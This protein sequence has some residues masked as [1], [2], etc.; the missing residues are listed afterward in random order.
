MQCQRCRTLN[1]AGAQFCRACGARLESLC[2]RCN[3]RLEAD[4]RFCDSCGTDLATATTAATP[5]A[6]PAPPVQFGSPGAYTPKHLA[7]KILTS[8][9][10]LEGERK[11]V[12]VLFVD[13]SGFTSLS[14]R[15]DPEDVHRFM[16]RAFELMLEEVHRYEGTVNQF[17]GDGIMALFGAPIAHEDHAQRAV[18]AALGIAKTLESYHDELQRKRAITFQVRQGLNTGLVVVGSIGSDLRMDYTAVGDTTNIAARLQ[19]HADRGRIVISESCHRLVDGYFHT[20]ALGELTLKG[21]AE[22]VRAWEVIAARQART[23]LEIEAERGLT[24]YVGREREVRG[25]FEALEKAKA[26]HGQVVFIVGEAGIGKSRLLYEFRRRLGEEATWNEGRCM[27]FGR[28]IALHPVVDMLKRTFRIDEADTEGTIAKKVERGVLL[29]G[30]DLRPLVPYLRYVLSVDPG[31]PAV[32]E[33]DPQRR[34]AEIFDA[35]RRL[36]LRASEV[37]PQVMV[38]E[39]VHWMDKATEESLQFIMDSVPSNRL[40]VILTYRPGYAQPWGDRSYH[41]RIALTALTQQD[42][43]QMAQAML[44]TESLPPELQRLIVQK[45][46]GNPFFVEEVVK[47]LQEVGAIRRDGA[48]YTIARHLDEI[49]I[50]DTIQDVIMARIDRLAEAPKKTLQLASVIGREFTQRLL[51]RIA[52]IRGST[53]EFLRELK[54]IELIYEKRLFPELAYMFKHALTHDVAYNS[55][56]I[57]RRREL[58]RIIALAIEELY[59]DRLAEQYEMLAYHFGKAED[60]ARAFDYLVKAADK[61]AQTFANREAVALLDQALEAAEHLG[62]TVTVETR[63]SIH[64]SRSGMFFMLSD[65]PRSH[66]EAARL[67]ELARGVGDPVKEAAALAGMGFASLWA[68]DFEHALAES[69]EAIDVGTRAEAKPVLAAGH[70]TTG[71]VLAVTARLDEAQR[72]MDQTLTFSRAA[73]DKVHEAFGLG[74]SALL[75]NWE[76]RYGDAERLAADGLRVARD[77]GVVLPLYWNFFINTV[78]LGGKGDYEAALAAG[79]NGLALCEKIG[80]EV[81]YQRELNCLGWLWSE[82]GELGLAFDYNR[83]CAD[84]ARKR[85]DPETTANAEINLADIAIAQGDVP[86]AAEILDGVHRLVKNPSTSD[87]MRWRYSTHL[88]ASLADLCLA[89]GDDRKAAEWADECLEIATRTRARKNL[90]KGWRARGEIA[91]RQGRWDDAEH[92][93]REALTVALAVDNPGQLWRTHAALG[94]LREAQRRDKDAHAAYTAGLGVIDRMRAGLTTPET[95][96]ALDRAAFVKK[97]AERVRDA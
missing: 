39:D 8:R 48:R 55:I 93:L 81:M 16:T 71:F 76:G 63:M 4:A 6:A 47:S 95:R 20:R 72:E 29:L 30:E 53:E 49:L 22:P 26:G 18:H 15:L 24:P 13:V 66:A 85:G 32:R 1:R 35:L 5:P 28:S 86:L 88:F 91:T 25:L 77:S 83:R 51:D 90:V 7:E 43:A 96:A 82:L 12:T 57:Q 34:R 60:W 92:A 58:H 37:R 78:V 21:K 23:R 84:G 40:L 19:Q 2:P 64:E 33:M 89:R 50:P 68:H 9:S 17:L 38:H 75:K 11:Q 59:A 62:D 80:D 69:R 97:L 94:R 67:L 61:S 74:M 3:A 10:A 54:S 65:F 31:D 45:A 36:L 41:T 46:E 73:G 79:H 56:L 70:F 87:W 27:S 52:D 44:G 14:E 42:S